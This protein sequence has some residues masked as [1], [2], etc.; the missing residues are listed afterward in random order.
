[1]SARKGG[2]LVAE[3]VVIV[4]G[5]LVALAVDSW[6]EE[7]QDEVLLESYSARL[8]VEFGINRRI[9]DFVKNHSTNG[10]AAT[11]SL[12]PFFERNERPGG[13]ARVAAN[14]YN[15]SRRTGVAPVTTTFDDLVSTGNL[16]LFDT[17]LR[18]GLV[19]TYAQLEELD[20]PVWFGSSYR[21]IVRGMLPIELQLSIRNKCGSPS[22]ADWDGCPLPFDEYNLPK[23]MEE[24]GESDPLRAAFRLQVHDLAV[25]FRDLNRATMSIDSVL[26]LLG[27]D[28]K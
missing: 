8:G 9:L 4:L 13:A 11:D 22:D 12:I 1:V 17:G 15:A 26:V 3:F 6:R 18:T 20:A 16:R 14:A 21:R 10:A 7:R 19:S 2:W 5:V 28:D 25:F 23:V 27:T 24:L